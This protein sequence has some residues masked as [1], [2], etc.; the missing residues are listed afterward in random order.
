[1]LFAPPYVPH[2]VMMRYKGNDVQLPPEAEEVA[3]F[4]GAMLETEH[5]KKP[6]FVS[7][8]F[9]DFREVL[10]EYPPVRRLSLWARLIAQ[11]DGTKITKFDDCDFRPIFDWCETERLRKKAMTK[12]EK[13]AVR[14]ALLWSI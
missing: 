7:N 3:T 12:E 6:V 10:K 14:A 2:G 9:E 1:M 13:K 4:F 5:V 11:L 8:F